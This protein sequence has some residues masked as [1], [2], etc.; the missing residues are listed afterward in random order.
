MDDRDS[1]SS[2]TIWV[3]VVP[4]I[5]ILL[6]GVVPQIANHFQKKAQS[7]SRATHPQKV[8]IEDGPEPAEGRPSWKA[9]DV[10]IPRYDE[11]HGNLTAELTA[12][13]LVTPDLEHFTCTNPVLR[14]IQPGK[15]TVVTGDRGHG[16][17]TANSLSDVT[18]TGHV[19][20]RRYDLETPAEK[21]PSKESDE[22]LPHLYL[23]G[24][25]KRD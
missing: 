5:Y 16:K 15:L 12:D 7:K 10:L 1:K 4:V 18:I 11:V 9:T 8:P 22:K 24:Q 6:V 19:K 17:L 2:F 14:T 3:L 20:V 13:K 25:S 21:A 23:P